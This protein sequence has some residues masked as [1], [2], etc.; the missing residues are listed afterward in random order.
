[1]FIRYMNKPFFLRDTM[2]MTYQITL[3]YMINDTCIKEADDFFSYHFCHLRFKFSLKISYRLGS[4]FHEYC[5]SG[6]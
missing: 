3:F 2:N 5:V 1:V 4:I 6:Y